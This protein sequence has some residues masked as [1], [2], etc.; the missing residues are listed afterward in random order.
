MTIQD[1]QFFLRCYA[2]KSNHKDPKKSIIHSNFPARNLQQRVPLFT[3]HMPN[4]KP[5]IP[6]RSSPQ[7]EVI[8][9]TNQVRLRTLCNA[10]PLPP[11]EQ[12]L[13]LLLACCC[14]DSAR[15]YALITPHVRCT[16]HKKVPT[17]AVWTKAWPDSLSPHR[18][19]CFPNWVRPAWFQSEHPL[20]F[21]VVPLC[22]S[23]N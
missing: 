11:S 13:L 10:L 14:Y 15:L 9:L 21:T 4:R 16:G 5:V 7:S 6:W 20:T 22:L 8:E 3:S 1:R 18:F 12:L 2:L 23:I 17:P 19:Y